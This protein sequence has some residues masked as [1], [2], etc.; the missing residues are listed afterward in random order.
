MHYMYGGTILRVNLNNTEISKE[1]TETYARDFLGGRGVNI[2]FLYDETTPGL[3]PF[4]PDSP[5]IF[6]IGPMSGTPVPSLNNSMKRRD[7]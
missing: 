5:L 3:D 7:G 4:D 6:G 1:P 2:K